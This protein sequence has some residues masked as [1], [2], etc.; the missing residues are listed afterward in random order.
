MFASSFWADV[1]VFA[2]A[3]GSLVF[4][5]GAG[6]GRRLSV[7]HALGDGADAKAKLGRSGEEG[8][9]AYYSAWGG[10]TVR[11]L[12]VG[13]RPMNSG[14]EAFRVL[15]TDGIQGIPKSCHQVYC[16][17]ALGPYYLTS[18]FA[19]TDEFATK[20]RLLSA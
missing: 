15:S 4:S 9:G 6:F 16:I 19:M 3:T 1:E 17:G 10:C 7:E 14:A 8:R 12:G 2:E 13:S 11:R 5:E 18:L 20:S